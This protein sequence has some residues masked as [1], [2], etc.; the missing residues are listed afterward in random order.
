MIGI[1]LLLLPRKILHLNWG[2]LH[3]KSEPKGVIIILGHL[4]SLIYNPNTVKSNITSTIVLQ[5][6]Q[7]CY[8]H[9]FG[10]NSEQLSIWG[11]YLELERGEEHHIVVKI[12]AKQTWIWSKFCH[13]VVWLK[14]NYFTLLNISSL[15]I[16]WVQQ[17]YLLQ[18]AVFRINWNKMSEASGTWECTS[19]TGSVTETQV[20]VPDT[21]A[22]EAKQYQTVRVWNRERFIEGHARRWLAHALKTPNSLKTF[23]KALF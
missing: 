7:H 5:Y 9:Q 13:L 18:G 23:S 6:Y 12:V 22:S 14:S 10:L 15:T 2:L 8:H 3:T 1:N 20:H 16:K 19:Y 11:Y 17:E 21:M 4:G